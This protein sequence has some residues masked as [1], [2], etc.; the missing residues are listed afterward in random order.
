MAY[1]A[2]ATLDRRELEA[3]QLSERYIERERYRFD[4]HTRAACGL[5]ERCGCRAD[6][7]DAD[8]L[9]RL[10]DNLRCVFNDHTRRAQQA[11]RNMC[12]KQLR[13]DALVGMHSMRKRVVDDAIFHESLYLNAKIIRNTQKKM[14]PSTSRVDKMD[15]LLGKI[16]N[17]DT[18]TAIATA[19]EDIQADAQQCATPTT[20][21]HARL[22][23]K[24]GLALMDGGHCD[25]VTH[26]ILNLY[27][28]KTR[29]DNGCAMI[30]PSPPSCTID[31]DDD[32]DFVA[33]SDTTATTSVDH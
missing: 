21:T 31:D 17:A 18:N 24:A 33:T 29:G 7:D 5:L 12:D 14:H 16:A 27:R 15:K 22:Y 28:R 20:E 13:H 30:L 26:D 10:P 32:D 1:A 19:I 3:M 25:S 9:D 8:L 6:D 4:M 23:D 11:H 2:A